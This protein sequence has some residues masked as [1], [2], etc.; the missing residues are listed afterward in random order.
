M[1][2]RVTGSAW[3]P[4]GPDPIEDLRAFAAD[5]REHGAQAQVWR[6]HRRRTEEAAEQEL[7]LFAEIERNREAAGD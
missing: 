7:R 6:V 1:T 3:R 5:L 4:D 2:D